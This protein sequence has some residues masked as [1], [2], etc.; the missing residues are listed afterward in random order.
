MICHTCNM[1]I[2]NISDNPAIALRIVK[3]LE[4]VELFNFSA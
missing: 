4:A 1:V 2:G 3:Y